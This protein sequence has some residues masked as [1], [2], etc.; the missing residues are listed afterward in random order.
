MSCRHWIASIVVACWLG[1]G[2][3]APAEDEPRW[4][5]IEVRDLPAAVARSLFTSYP[6]EEIARSFTAP[7]LKRYRAVMRFGSG[8]RWLVDLTED[9]TFTGGRDL[10]DGMALKELPA[11]VT[12]AAEAYS[13]DA[14]LVGAWL[15][16]TR[17]RRVFEL[18]A[19][20]KGR[21]MILTV[22]PDG[23]LTQ[24]RYEIL[25]SELPRAVTSTIQ[26]Q[27]PKQRILRAERLGD[28][29]KEPT[30][31]D[32]IVAPMQSQRSTRVRLDPAG[33]LVEAIDVGVPG[34]S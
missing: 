20:L 12:R 1:S 22:T 7:D 28:G 31:F 18:A 2:A 25:P 34:Q 33:K 11:E 19:K 32:V 13:R 30:S 9:G 16:G 23:T 27:Y 14:T 5:E 29:K 6:K 10:S 15:V 21:E 4:K 17:R 3:R 8:A 24:T 26:E